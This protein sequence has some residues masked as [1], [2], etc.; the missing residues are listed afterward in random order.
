MAFR[1][2]VVPMIVDIKGA[3]RPKYFQDGTIPSPP[4]GFG[5]IYYAAEPW[6]LVGADLPP[7]D[8]ATIA[9]QADVEALPVDLSPH[10]TGGQVTGTRAF[11]EAASI[12]AG[13]VTTADTWASVVRGVAGMFLFLQRYEGIYSIANNGAAPSIFLGGVTLDSTF[14]SLPALVQASMLATATDQNI[15]TSGLAAGTTLRVI[16]RYVA[17]FYSSVPIVIAG[18]SI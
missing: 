6:A 7:A 18:V 4:N 8:D 14:G 3:R 16:W 9:G 17:D 2:Y 11:L 10:L 5:V 12:P 15:P 13:W 1:I